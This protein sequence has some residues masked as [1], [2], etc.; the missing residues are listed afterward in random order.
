[1]VYSIVNFWATISPPT[2]KLPPIP[3]PPITFK[4]PVVV[5]VAEV[6]LLT[7]IAANVTELVVYKS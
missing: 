3:T 7:D 4:A 2:Y 1:V 6:L 5:L